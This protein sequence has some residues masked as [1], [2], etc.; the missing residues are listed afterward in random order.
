MTGS[1]ARWWGIWL[2]VAVLATA[3]LR[4]LRGHIDLSHVEIVYLVLVLGASA[5]G[6]GAVGLTV[7]AFAVAAIDF[8]FQ[9]PFDEFAVDKGVDVY[10]LAAF[11]AAALVAT[12]LLARARHEAEE[13]RR[14][15]AETRRYA[16]DAA[17]AEAAAD[18]ARLK[19]LA[20]AA[21]S[22]DLRTPLTT[23]K[24]LAQS[25][26]L[27]ALPAGA[28]IG[29]QVDVLTALVDGAID[30]TRAE[31]A[32][33]ALDV[34]VNMAEDVLGA[35]VRQLRGV[36]GDRQLAVR[37]DP[38]APLAGEFDFV[39]TLRILTNLAENALRVSPA[40]GVVEVSARAAGEW[41]EFVVADRG[42]GIAAEHAETV[43]EPFVRLRGAGGAS[44][45][46]GLGLAIARRLAAAQGGTLRHAP[47][48]G[49]G[50]EF[51]LRVRRAEP[52]VD[53]LPS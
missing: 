20:L 17:R 4:A 11:L 10:M 47:R 42:P 40:A 23:I 18:A 39:Q 24:A 16:A 34:G 8:F 22:H 41:L 28:A 5:T 37:A 6:G 21:I 45:H 27:A 14:Q 30:L 12:A 46:A 49:G 2:T 38:G 25:E 53:E 48:T 52:S 51:T 50:T 9:V 26:P 29:E 36:V 33:L 15:A 32:T 43:F 35:M 3:V 31:Q 7:A 13:A 1:P 19:E 44:G